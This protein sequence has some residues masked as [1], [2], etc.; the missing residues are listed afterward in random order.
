MATTIT[1]APCERSG[2]QDGA[3][4]GSIRRPREAARAWVHRR[5]QL[6]ASRED[7]G[8]PDPRDRD[9]TLLHRLAQRLEDVASELGQLIEEQDALVGKGAGTPE[10]RALRFGQPPKIRFKVT[11]SSG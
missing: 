11:A 8:P 10:G 7:R 9:A 1:K 3:P 6:E 2:H 5:D 4:A